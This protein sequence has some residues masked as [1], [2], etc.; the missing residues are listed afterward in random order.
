MATRAQAAYPG[1]QTVAEMT[2]NGHTVQMVNEFIETTS[3]LPDMPF[4]PS[5]DALEDVSGIVDSM[6]AGHWTGLDDG[7]E[8]SKGG[9]KQ[10]TEKMGI[11][12]DWAEYNEKHNIILGADYDAARWQLDQMHIDALGLEVER[13]LLYGNPYVNTPDAQHQ[14][15]GFIPRMNHITNMHGELATPFTDETGVHRTKSPYVVLDAGGIASGTVKL[16]SILLVAHGPLGATMIY[17]KN[18]RSYGMIYDAF[19]FENND[20]ASANKRVAKSRFMWMGGLRI[21]NRR[22]VVRIANI[23][24]ADANLVPTLNKLMLQAFQS[25]PQAYQSSVS[26]YANS[27]TIVAYNAGLNSRITPN[28]YSDAGLQNPLSNVQ[29]GGFRVKRC[30]SLLRDEAQVTN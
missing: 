3:I 2:H 6:P 21:P 27:D 15:L 17:P 10:R 24:P 30:E 16:S 11:Y 28:T 20:D 25:I 19:G 12:E 8:T 14:F 29:I 22:T 9:F 13:C 7:V 26:I 5:T 1:M 4:A 18:V 23:N